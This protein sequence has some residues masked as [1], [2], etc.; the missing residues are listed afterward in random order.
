VGD[1]WPEARVKDLLRQYEITV[2]DGVIVP[3]G[4]LVDDAANLAG[5]L[6]RPLVVK[7]HDSAILHKTDVGGVALSIRTD[8]VLRETIED[9]KNRFPESELLIEE[10]A[11]A[12]VEFIIGMLRDAD[13]GLSIMAGFGG[14]FTEIYQDVAFR[15][16]PVSRADCEDML[17]HLTAAPLLDEYRGQKAD[18]EA[19]VDLM[20]KVNAFAREWGPRLEGMDLNPVLVHESGVTVVDA[21]LIVKG[22]E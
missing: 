1:Q 9:F 7:V 15:V 19:L 22:E 18:R 12:G 20:L 17:S 4:T 14:I 2:P 13:F 8:T 10:Q 6:T 3:P 11:P 21:K 5:D 16:L